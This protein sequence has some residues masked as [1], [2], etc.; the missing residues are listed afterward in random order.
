M[1]ARRYVNDKCVMHSKCLLD[2]GTL[3]LLGSTQVCP[4]I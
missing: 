3:G 1:E 2:G 4:M